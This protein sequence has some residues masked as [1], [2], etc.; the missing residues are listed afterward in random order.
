[1]ASKYVAVAD[2]KFGMDRRRPRAAGV[3]GT[4]WIGKN[5]HI[6]RGGDIERAKKFVAV[7]TLPTGTFGL[8]HLNGQLVVFGSLDL[9]GS[10]PVGVSYIRLNV[11]VGLNMSRVLYVTTFAG[12]TCVIAEYDDGSIF[13]WVGTNRVTELDALNE[14]NSSF[15]SLADFLARLVNA[16]AAVEAVA[17]ANVIII[18][19][20]VPGTAFTLATST[21]NGGAVN[22]QTAVATTVQANVAEVAEVRATGTVTVTAGTR[23]PG[24]NRITQIDVDGT[25]LLAAPVDWIS[26]HGATAVAL[27]QGINNETANSGYS[28]A[29]VGA[30]VTIKA[31]VG[32][33]TAANGLVIHRFTAGDVVL[34][35]SG[36]MSGGVNAV[37][38]VAQVSKVTLGGTYE[39]LDK[40][41]ITINGTNYPA[42]GRASGAPTQWLTYKTRLYAVAN[43][44]LRYSKINTPLD[45]T[46]A[47]V[48]SGA[49]FINLVNDFAGSQ[50]LI[51]VVSYQTFVA[52]FARETVSIYDLQADAE[53]NVF[54]Q[55]IENTGAVSS[56]SVVRYG[57]TDVFYLDDTGIRSLE[58]RDISNTAAVGDVGSAIDTF[59][60]E[61]IR[62]ISERT[63]ERAV[64]VIDPIDGRFLM[65]IGERIYVLSYFPASKIKAW[66]YYEPGFE[67]TDL[68]RVNR[69]IYARDVN[70]IYLYGGT[71]NLVYPDENEQVAVVDLPFLTA[72]TPATFKQWTGFDLICEGV[73]N[74]EMLVDP[75]DDTKIVD[76]GIVTKTTNHLPAHAL[77]GESPMFAPRFTCNSAGQAKISSFIAHYDAHEAD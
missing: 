9:A 24:V 73:W 15:A 56:R 22:D 58:V 53:L 14:T 67:A 3:P 25:N 54:R 55:S 38:P 39:G 75:T 6:S 40:F 37:A 28:A 36:T 4:I 2:F 66:S 31:A 71:T 41:I 10:M 35:T 11:G 17:L 50:R 8:H 57:N 76:G 49:G 34:G 7:E 42:N 19:A 18:T 13:S 20:S 44:L 23:S 45:W 12:E 61:H 68:L 33:G 51:A 70:T 62:Q 60:A 52:I 69:R 1:M 64:A 16:D 48:S 27:T 5:I 47:N 30:V 46:D 74:V 43:T 72:Q 63:L 32:I 29:A 77:V 26:S 59:V 65:A 21:L